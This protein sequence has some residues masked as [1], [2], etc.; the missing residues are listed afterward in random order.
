MMQYDIG[1]M[2]IDKRCAMLACTPVCCAMACLSAETMVEA[3]LLSKRSQ[4]RM[5][6]ASAA[7]F[8][9]RSMR[10]TPTGGLKV[11]T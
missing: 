5:P 10:S 2:F 1:C 8:V 3:P 11:A 4:R 9:T 7:R 6:G